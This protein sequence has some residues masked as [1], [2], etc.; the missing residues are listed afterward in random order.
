LEKTFRLIVDD[1]Y[2]SYK[3]LSRSYSLSIHDENET[4]F[5]L[6]RDL[7]LRISSMFLRNVTLVNTKNSLFNFHAINLTRNNLNLTFS[8]HFEL[9]SLNLNLS[10]LLI[11]K[12]N[13]KPQLNSHHGWTLFCSSKKKNVND[14]IYTHFIDNSRTLNKYF[15]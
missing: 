15:P 10:Y 9:S 4:E 7:K 2:S 3:N 6:L 5:F 12:F 8:I 11:Y 13:D 1:Q 14:E